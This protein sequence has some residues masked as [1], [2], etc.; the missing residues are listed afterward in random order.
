MPWRHGLLP[1]MSADHDTTPEHLGQAAKATFA[2]P[3]ALAT[4]IPCRSV[5]GNRLTRVRRSKHPSHEHFGTCAGLSLQLVTYF[6]DLAVALLSLDCAARKAV[7]EGSAE[8]RGTPQ[9]VPCP[10]PT[11][12][13]SF[14]AKPCRCGSRLPPMS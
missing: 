9:E 11:P 8:R 10:A 1:R 7:S 4:W 6:R 2:H 14:Y 5:A 13:C 3:A 12:P